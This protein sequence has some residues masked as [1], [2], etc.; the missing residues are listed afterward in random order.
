MVAMVRCVGSMI[1]ELLIL[2]RIDGISAKIK[3]NKFVM[4]VLCSFEVK[5]IAERF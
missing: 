5:S 2:S 4:F 3:G 1:K